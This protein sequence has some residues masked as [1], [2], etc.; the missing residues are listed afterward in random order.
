MSGIERRRFFRI[1]DKVGLRCQAV[2][3]GSGAMEVG[4]QIS[5]R[6]GNEVLVLEQQ[7]RRGIEH[8]RSQGQAVA[9]VLDLINR[10]LNVVM[11]EEASGEV[12]QSESILTEVS[13]SA[14][15]LAFESPVFAEV[16]SRIRIEMVLMPDHVRLD[17][18]GMV[19]QR[20]KVSDDESEEGP[21]YLLR[22]DF[23]DL[24]EEN[25]EMLIQHVLRCQTR[26]LKHR[27][28]S[29]E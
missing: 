20:Q 6:F 7:I 22:V 17:I 15:G 28:E 21:R 8:L 10:K 18:E 4:E 27:R 23:L 26:E 1:N 5:K 25:Q 24:D 16:G 29:R 3:G 9:V 2:D 13:L 11:N 14:C 19:I 12:F